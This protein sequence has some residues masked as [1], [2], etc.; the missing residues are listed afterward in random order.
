MKFNFNELLDVW[1]LHCTRRCSDESVWW[2]TLG[3][4]SD[5]GFKG[6]YYKQDLNVPLAN[7]QQHGRP[8]LMKQAALASLLVEYTDFDENFAAWTD[9]PWDNYG[10]VT[11]QALAHMT[12]SFRKPEPEM[13]RQV[14]SNQ[15]Y[16]SERS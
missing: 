10:T 6:A 15:R 12:T 9:G 4:N 2:A 13:E 3:F 11:V 14:V 5:W 1:K 8:F 7:S 16:L